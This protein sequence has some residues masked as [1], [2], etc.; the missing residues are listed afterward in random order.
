MNLLLQSN[1]VRHLTL[2]PAVS[3]WILVPA[4]IA[5]ALMVYYLY[6]AQRQIASARIVGLLTVIR[7]SLIGLLAILLLRPLWVWRE[8]HTS[9]ETL[10]VVLDQS[11]S[12]GQ[13]DP[14]ASPVERLRWADALGLLPDEARP[15]KLDRSAARLSA[16][17][18]E[19]LNLQRPQAPGA[20][21]TETAHIAA[22][23]VQS[24]KTWN[25]HLQDTAGRLDKDPRIASANAQAIPADLHKAADDVNAALALAAQKTRPELAAA[26][27]PWQK[28]GERLDAA[29][30]KLI[31]LSDSADAEFLAQ[32][33]NDPAV[34]EPLAKVAQ[35]RRADVAY[36]ALTGKSRDLPKSMADTLDRQNTRVLTFAGGQ[37]IV[38]TPTKG[39]I[40]KAI[41]AGVEPIGTSTNI[42]G[43]L[44]FVS[45][46][47][48]QGERASVL[49]V[50]D[51][52]I[53]DGG[54]PADIAARLGERGVRVF[55][56]A[57]GSRQVAPDAAVE[58]VDAPDWIYK[59]DTFKTSALLR[60]DGLAGKPVQVEFLR[61]STLLNTQTIT[62]ASSQST[63]VVTFKDKPPEPDVYQYTVHVKEMPN[64]V[65]KENNTQT[66]RVSVKNDKLHV[67]LVE[68]QPRWEDRYVANYLKRDN[69]VQLQHV[70]L[71]AARVAGVE[72]PPKV[73]ATAT[74]ATDMAQLL[75][76]TAEEWSAFDLIILGDI[77]TEFLSAETQK[78]I[79]TA[80]RDRG[81]ALLVIA[82][83]L[84]MPARYTGSPLAELLPVHLT[85]NW[86]AAALA[87]HLKMGFRPRVSSEGAASILGQLGLDE[88]TNG[89]YWSMMPAWFWHSEQTQAKQSATVLWEIA[90]SKQPADAKD[91]S[92]AAGTLAESRQRALLSTMPVGLGRVMYLASDSTWRMRQVDG[93]NLHERFWGQVIRWVVQSD[94]P[95][96]GK[97]V[98]FGASKPR[99]LAGDSVVVTIRMTNESFS[100]LTGQQF[101]VVAR[102]VMPKD[103]AAG[104]VTGG[105]TVATADAVEA[106]ESPGLYRATLSGL[107][108]G[109]YQIELQGDPIEKFLRSDPVATQ[110]ELLVDV[111]S[112]SD[113]ELQNVNADRNAL[114]RLSQ[115]GNG[116]ATSAEY[117]DVLA[118]HIP[119]LEK[120]VETVQ[121]IG[122]FADKDNPYVKKAHWGFLIAFVT[123]I[124]AEWIIR[125]AGGLV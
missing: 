91:D 76:A 110:K 71:E 120:P 119:N 89:Q 33:Q 40:P 80:V 65:V 122:L 59:D 37:Q 111:L 18:D 25:E 3:A 94:L 87:E 68:D 10:W 90:D 12:M 86:S 14:Q 67:I 39:E 56:L 46:Q 79:A 108:P 8:S 24:L 31:P 11:L 96:G 82:G 85:S 60:L 61:G 72:A 107:K 2:A 26:E 43:A 22:G 101:K 44:R 109:G 88:Q 38:A 95:A 81:A 74:A 30:T 106:P 16:L 53:N 20:D 45:E 125:K 1:I 84:N 48:A 51:G 57:L 21:D 63:A 9:G 99:Y 70:L 19:L 62:P 54:D 121:T 36:G 123:L 49:I 42:S 115:A 50:S 41:K 102:D 4:L 116:I 5:V 104:K 75:P 55:T 35:L 23:L 100:P 6:S 112:G 124:T 27:I 7:L 52:R 29:I 78:N 83:P 117:A 17:R 97:F 93:V 15:S 47:I 105:A 92:K 73:K 77:P 98:R 32:H 66:F 118:Q 69:R 64:E 28:T 103:P 13:K 113:R 34:T 58:F 114:S